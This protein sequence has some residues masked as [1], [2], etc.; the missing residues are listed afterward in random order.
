MPVYA[1][2]L[3][4]GEKRYYFIARNSDGK[5]IKKSG[6]KRQSD[7]KKAEE[8]FNVLHANSKDARFDDYYL[9]AYLP[10]LVN[11]RKLKP[12]YIDTLR[13]MFKRFSPF[14][15]MK[16]SDCTTAKFSR[17]FIGLAKNNTEYYCLATY[18]KLH[19]F[20]AYVEKTLNLQNPLTNLDAPRVSEHK[21]KILWTDK[22]YHK[23]I[24]ILSN[25]KRKSSKT[26]ALLIE[27]LYLCGLRISEAL[28][29]TSEDIV[30]ENDV[31]KIKV[32]KVYNTNHRKII[33]STK[34][35]KNREV[36]INQDLF[37]H[38]KTFI[39]ENR[40][41]ANERIFN[42]A[43]TTVL[44]FLYRFCGKNKLPKINLHSLRAAHTTML[45]VEG[46]N[47]SAVAERLGHNKEV[48]F[49]HYVEAK[50]NNTEIVNLLNKHQ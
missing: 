27:V 32:N 20:F 47:P 19:A 50:Q 49:K 10:Y 26:Y 31:Y 35:N 38:F 34:T 29:L 5:Q 28:A 23:A 16:L 39:R 30:Y 37:Y 4:T 48:M 11:V 6:F 44:Q 36:L 43:R 15:K 13:Y 45:I 7:A 14:Y 46:V 17:F 40:I 22:E 41:S 18:R 25:S 3:K 24:E 2:F 42:L 21:Q 8:R 12:T 33:H 9:N 1:Y